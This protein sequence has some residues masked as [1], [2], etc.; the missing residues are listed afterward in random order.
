M[1]APAA[2]VLAETAAVT[3]LTV[4][5]KNTAKGKKQPP[6]SSER[7]AAIFIPAAEAAQRMG[8]VAPVEVALDAR[9]HPAPTVLMV[10]RIQEAVVAPDHG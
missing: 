8:P 1:E 4:Q 7:Q 9:L 5:V 6:E 2:V 3:A 10:Q